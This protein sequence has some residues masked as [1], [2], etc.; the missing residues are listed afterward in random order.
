MAEE[1]LWAELADI[2]GEL[3]P[4]IEAFMAIYQKCLD[5]G[6]PEELAVHFVK[7]L[8]GERIPPS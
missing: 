5:A 2:V 8:M 4:H 7:L 1:E 6:M 3:A